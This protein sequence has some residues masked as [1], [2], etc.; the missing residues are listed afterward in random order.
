MGG[1]ALFG[2]TVSGAF[3]KSTDLTG[4]DLNRTFDRGREELFRRIAELICTRGDTFTVYVV[5]QSLL[6]TGSTKTPK[7]TGTQRLRVTFRLVPKLVDVKTGLATDF[8]PGYTV[9]SD[10]TL[11]PTMM[12]NPD[13]DASAFNQRFRKPD[14]YDVQVLQVNAY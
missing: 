14:R 13:P 12:A 3:S 11:T 5:G 1:T 9:S 2:K 10:G 8:H 7:I 6:Q 4:V